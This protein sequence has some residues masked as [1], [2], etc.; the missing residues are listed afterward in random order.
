MPLSIDHVAALTLENELRELVAR[1][2]KAVLCDLSGTKYI[3]SSGLR[4]FL[5]TAKMAKTSRI[6]FGLFAITPFVDRILSLSGFMSLFVIYDSE[7]AALRAV[8]RL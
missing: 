6:H 8:S 2:P 5:S 1:Q 4:I 7:E 3:S